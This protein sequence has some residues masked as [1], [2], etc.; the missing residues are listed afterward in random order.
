[1]FCANCGTKQNEG[2]KFCPNCGTKFEEPLKVEEAKVE[3]ISKTEKPKPEDVVP[4][5]IDNKVQ[6]EAQTTK[7]EKS[8]SVQNEDYTSIIETKSSKGKQAKVKID[9]P[10]KT[11]EPEECNIIQIDNIEKNIIVGNK[12]LESDNITKHTERNECK[13]TSSPQAVDNKDLKEL[14]REAEKGN[15]EAQMRLAI[16]YEF[17]L[18]IDVDVDKAKVLYSKI[19]ENTTL[20]SLVPLDINV[21]TGVV[22]DAYK[23]EYELLYDSETE[24]LMQIIQQAKIREKEENRRKQQEEK[25]KN[26]E[27]RLSRDEY[28]VV[29][30]CVKVDATSKQIKELIKKINDYNCLIK[31]YNYDSITF[32]KQKSLVKG[33]FEKN[34]I[35]SRKGFFTFWG[36]DE[37]DREFRFKHEF[38]NIYKFC[39]K[40][41]IE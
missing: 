4:V 32:D 12:D 38:G 6:I 34:Y 5:K 41:E 17:G 3:E 1:M 9:E 16:K 20:E 28:K 11:L 10:T 36:M 14:I 30:F 21:R 22:S 39:L 33:R 13:N 8:F 27:N 26:I 19:K 31:E 24:G 35:W 18:G 29:S 15:V 7:E 40:L 37:Y 2:E 25:Y 23:I